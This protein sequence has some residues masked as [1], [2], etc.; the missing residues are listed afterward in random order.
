MGPL[1]AIL[2][3]LAVP[4]LTEQQQL[5]LDTARDG[6]PGWD[7]AA[8]YPLLANVVSW[9]PGDESG[10]TI[11]D[12][13]ALHRD[14]AK[15]R[16]QFFLVEGILGGAPQLMRHRFARPGD[17]EKNS[18]QWPILI[19]R[20][21]DEVVIILM[22]DPMPAKQLPTRGGAKVRVAARFFKTW[23]VVDRD[24]IPTDYL[25]FVGRSAKV[26][27]GATAITATGGGSSVTAR[28]WV[29]FLILFA[30][31]AIWYAVRRATKLSLK[32]RPLKSK[33]GLLRDHVPEE[34]E[35]AQPGEL[36]KD[37]A[38]ALEALEQRHRD[39]S[40]KTDTEN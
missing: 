22:L 28:A 15:Y 7:E 40:E 38:A 16:G 6:Q 39:L 27:A 1:L 21:P 25:F 4:P 33:R 20:N 3:L 29:A 8:L 31:G 30:L 24:N 37:P 5:Q 34:P 13:D 19:S 9:S 36:P 23:N 12:Y 26:E 11:P 35:E 14:P 17:W 10:A 2:L 32:G 18:Q